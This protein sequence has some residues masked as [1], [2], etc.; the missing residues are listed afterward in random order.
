[1]GTK[2]GSVAPRD[3]VSDEDR[4]AYTAQRAAQCITTQHVRTRNHE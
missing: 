1:V 3:V 2:S 4:Y